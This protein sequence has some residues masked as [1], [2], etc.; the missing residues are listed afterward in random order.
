MLKHRFVIVTMLNCRAEQ[1]AQQLEI[2]PKRKIQFDLNCEDSTYIFKTL[3][4][5]CIQFVLLF[6]HR[7]NR[8]LCSHAIRGG[9]KIAAEKSREREEEEGVLEPSAYVIYRTHNNHHTD[10]GKNSEN[11]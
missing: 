5:E 1:A 6:V 11:E 7:L 4:A 10:E 9:V 3:F 2:K 8:L